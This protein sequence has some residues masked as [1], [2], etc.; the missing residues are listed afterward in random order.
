MKFRVLSTIIKNPLVYLPILIF[1]IHIQTSNPQ[2][3]PQVSSLILTTPF[4]LTELTDQHLKYIG[5][6]LPSLH[7]SDW[8][9]RYFLIILLRQHNRMNQQ[10]SLE[11]HHIF[12]YFLSCTYASKYAI[13]DLRRTKEVSL[14]VIFIGYCRRK[15]SRIK[16]VYH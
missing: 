2:E 12:I 15:K 14:E 6:L 3:P 5:N 8:R 16:I 4:S 10:V 11:I 1:A 13:M 9:N 7:S